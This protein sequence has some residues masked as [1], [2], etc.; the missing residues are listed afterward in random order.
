MSLST[1]KKEFYRTTANSRTAMKDPLKHSLR[2]WEGLQKKNLA[3]HGMNWHP[4]YGNKI[5]DRF[6]IAFRISESSCACC[7]KVESNCDQCPITILTGFDCDHEYCRS[8]TL[9]T[10]NPMIAL[11][12]KA[13][14]NRNRR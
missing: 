7:K 3:K 1:W 12:K 13:I 8:V 6:G 11:L 14:R 9:K 4:E 2:K 5:I 10:P